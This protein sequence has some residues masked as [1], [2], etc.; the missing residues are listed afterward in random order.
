MLKIFQQKDYS[1]EVQLVF[2]LKK[3]KKD[4]QTYLYERLA[5]KMLGLCL[6]YLKD[7]M[8]AEDVM[9]EGFMKVFSKID[10]Y[11]GE[12]SFEG[13]IK[14]IMVNECL[15]KLRGPKVYWLDSA[16]Y[17]SEISILPFTNLEVEEI[18]TIISHLPVGYRTVFNM[19]VI[20]GFSHAEIAEK[21]HISEGT[22]K[23]QLSRAKA[24]LREEI[25][26]EQRV[27]NQSK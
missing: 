22:S 1:D 11:R 17:E 19:Y 15:M 12:G 18:F 2:A 16:E 27:V 4:A 13:W 6:R 20:E 3:E 9:I 7:Q 21:L 23:S 25:E 24:L 14:R 5:P 10:L 8:Q 26:K